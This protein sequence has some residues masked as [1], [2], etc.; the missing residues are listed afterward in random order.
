M[1]AWIARLSW[2]SE[3]Y[4]CHGF[5]WT[6]LPVPSPLPIGQ[7][8]P[9]SQYRQLQSRQL[10][11]SS[12]LD[13]KESD[14]CFYLTPDL[15]YW[16]WPSQ[17]QGGLAPMWVCMFGLVSGIFSCNNN[18]FRNP[19]SFQN[20]IILFLYFSFYSI[21]FVCLNVHMCICVCTPQ[22]SCEDQK[23]TYRTQFSPSAM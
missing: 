18:L 10:W 13:I 8:G 7:H 17:S 22:C 21:D 3:A 12:D 20:P 9:Q 1:A 11:C 19:G 16:P 15:L 5:I 23:A 6:L 14:H 4:N 2:T